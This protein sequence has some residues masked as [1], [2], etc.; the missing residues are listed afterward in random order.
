MGNEA[1]NKEERQRKKGEQEEKMEIDLK[2]KTNQK[3]KSKFWLLRMREKQ[4]SL[5]NYARLVGKYAFFF[6]KNSFL[7]ILMLMSRKLVQRRDV[8]E[9]CGF[10]AAVRPSPNG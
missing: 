4:K 3:N 2:K 1:A 6:L 9:K 8:G 5:L 10:F 7:A